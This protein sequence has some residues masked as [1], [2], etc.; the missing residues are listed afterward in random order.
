MADEKTARMLMASA[1][2]NRP[3]THWM[4]GVGQMAKGYIGKGMMDEFETDR[5]A[6]LAEQKRLTDAQSLAFRQ[7]MGH[8]MGNKP[9]PQGWQGGVNDEQM[10]AIA[11]AQFQR[12]PQPTGCCKVKGG[13]A[14]STPER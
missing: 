14:L 8:V 5:N 2:Q 13:I 10:Q 1:L 9:L 7:N 6:K 11:N 12:R 4:Q 3:M